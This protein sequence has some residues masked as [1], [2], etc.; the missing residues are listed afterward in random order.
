MTPEYP[1]D[2]NFDILRTC[3]A[4]FVVLM[5]ARFLY[6]GDADAFPFNLAGVGVDGFFVISGFLMTWSLARQSALKPY[7]IKRAFRILPPY[8]LIVALQTAL[9]TLL[10]TP[11][12]PG[13]RSEAIRY[14]AANAVFLNFLKPAIGDSVDSLRVPAINGSL[15]TLKV[16][17]AF[18]IL[19]PAILFLHRRFGWA[20]LAFL[21]A[22]SCAYALVFPS[23]KWSQQFPGQMRFFTAGIAMFY[24]GY[25]VK[26]FGGLA[27]MASVG[28]GGLLLTWQAERPSIVLDPV[29]LGLL[30]YGVAFAPF[31]W[32]IHTDLSYSAY[33]IHFPLIQ[34]A[35]RE[36]WFGRSF[37][38]FLAFVLAATTA[39][40]WVSFRWIEKP[41]MEMGRRLARAA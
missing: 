39:L 35:L 2:N 11:G 18:Y 14:F 41:G 30:V 25:L 13:L 40:A 21:F 6:G 1:A 37:W 9:F 29:F 22:S 36:G 12:L 33:L 16:E 17:V 23:G 20:V 19:L 27:F 3:F 31:V 28:M 24:Y 5:H 8:L 26:R 7:A 38:Y 32:R 15:W 4:Y 34:I 10:A